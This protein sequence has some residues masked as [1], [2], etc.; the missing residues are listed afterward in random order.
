MNINNDGIKCKTYLIHVAVRTCCLSF[1]REK[2]DDHW[3][4]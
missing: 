2:G 4:E 1:V 3:E